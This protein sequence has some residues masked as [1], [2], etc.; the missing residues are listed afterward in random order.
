ML[1]DLLNLVQGYLDGLVATQD[2][3]TWLTS[4]LQPIIRSADPATV[5]L[6]DSIDAD[7]IEYGEGLIDEDTLR[8]RWRL[9]LDRVRI[10]VLISSTFTNVY[11]GGMTTSVNR[12]FLI[13][14][15]ALTSQYPVPE[16]SQT[17]SRAKDPRLTRPNHYVNEKGVVMPGHAA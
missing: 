6:A 16:A 3:E 13:D 4:R 15:G 17:E 2:V 5:Q 7:L 8:E 14:T 11:E 9:Y 10:R 12:H 1:Y